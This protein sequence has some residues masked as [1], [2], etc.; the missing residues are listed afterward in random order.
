MSNSSIWP[1]VRTL[2]GATTKGQCGPGSNSNEGVLLI[3]Q[4]SSITGTSSSDSLGS[5]PGPS[6]EMQSVYSTAPANRLKGSKWASNTLV[7]MILCHIL[8]IAE[9]LVKYAQTPLFLYIYV[10][11]FVSLSLSSFSLS[12]SLYIYLPNPSV[13]A[14]CDTSSFFS[15]VW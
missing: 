3:P 11:S 6:A 2:S 7:K 5:Y 12:L 13:Q 15:V 10:P 1:I 9:E 14:R 8:L 4:S